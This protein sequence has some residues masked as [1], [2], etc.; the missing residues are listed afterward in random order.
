[1]RIL[2]VSDRLSER[3]GAHWHLRSVI[4][5]LAALGH[6]VD[7]AVGA[8]DDEVT[9]P[10]PLHVVAGLDERRRR[11]VDLAPV[12][13]ATRPDVVH[14]HTVVNPSVLEWAGGVPAL[15]TVQDHRYFCPALGKWTA[16]GQVCRAPM[17]AR[18]CAACFDDG[19]YFHEVYG[20]TDERR[21][22]L[23]RLPVVVLSRYMRDELTAV[24]VP[25]ERIV[26]V[27][28]FVHGLDAGA[29]AGG[30]PC[31]LFAGR[32]AA[33]KG[34]REAVLAWRASGLDLPLVFAGT[35]PLRAELERDGLTV[36][37]WVPHAALAAVYRRAAA[38]LMPSR[39]QEPFGIVGLEARTLGTP[40]AAWRSGGVA[41][42]HDGGPSL[43]EWGDVPALAEALR[44]AAS[45][46]RST[47]PAGFEP[48]PLME[49]LLA[50]YGS[51]RAQ[52]SITGS[53]RREAWGRP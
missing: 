22:A 17:D 33:G 23:G 6:R 43:V 40:V 7:L 50:V 53:T 31:V 37:G 24:G 15:I 36:L 35:G 18:A 12:I 28:P 46:P 20:L 8:L 26:V 47:A 16:D 51:V 48:E 45:G 13:A 38:L 32:L 34:V 30:P 11:A 1:M 27:P 42:W 41:E 2:H 52:G 44:H 14:L 25:R 39:W 3:G 5:R 9:P 21:R 19:A 4:E 29:R 49:R 10:C